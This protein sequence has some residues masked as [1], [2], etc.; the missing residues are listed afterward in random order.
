ML[1]FVGELGF[2]LAFEDVEEWA[3]VIRKVGRCGAFFSP[4]DR[5][6]LI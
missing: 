4:D 3:G 5:D 6:R 1:W 2:G